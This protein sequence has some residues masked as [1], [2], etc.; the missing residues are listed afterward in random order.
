MHNI[1][2]LWA[3]GSNLCVNPVITT[4][5][6]NSQVMTRTRTVYRKET[7]DFAKNVALTLCWRSCT[8]LYWRKKLGQKYRMAYVDWLQAGLM[9]IILLVKF[10]RL[11]SACSSSR[12]EGCRTESQRRRWAEEL[13]PGWRR[14]EAGRERQKP[15]QSPTRGAVV[16]ASRLGWDKFPKVLEFCHPL[17]PPPTF[18]GERRRRNKKKRVKWRGGKGWGGWG[19]KGRKE[20]QTHGRVWSGGEQREARHQFF[21]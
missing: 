20:S 9:D 4:P 13:R 10:R 16:L 2:N 12:K 18:P 14:F 5:A 1:W 21:F 17:L 7:M 11:P 8:P 19:G 15:A 6:V 3:I